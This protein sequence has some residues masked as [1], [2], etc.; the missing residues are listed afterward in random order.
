MDY[1]SEII[2]ILNKYGI[3]YS[4]DSSNSSESAINVQCPL[5]DDRSDHCGIFRDSLVTKCWKCGRKGSFAYILS[6]IIN[7]SVQACESEL[8]S[9]GVS[10]DIDSEEQINRIFR[11]GE[12]EKP[13][14]RKRAPIAKYPK[15]CRPVE[16]TNSILLDNYLARRNIGI[17]VLIEHQCGC[18]LVGD[19]MNRLII[20]V[21]FEGNMVGFQ[22]ADMTGRSD[23]K[24]AADMKGSRIKEYFHRWDKL[25]RSLGYAIIVEGAPDAWRIG[26]NTLCSFGTSLTKEQKRLLISLD[27]KKLIFC[28]DGDAYMDMERESQYFMPFIPEVYVIKLPYYWRNFEER[29]NEDPDSWGANA[30]WD[31]ILTTCFE[32]S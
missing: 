28:P 22:A 20:P 8:E 13:E 14:V 12:E 32:R 24:Y 1:S 17:E 21:F 23:T 2:S 16:E 10:F 31:K 27:L 18:C 19:Y 9:F 4:E 3:P 26:N 11:G 30:V 15:Y 6:R 5:C 25:D 29:V 7:R